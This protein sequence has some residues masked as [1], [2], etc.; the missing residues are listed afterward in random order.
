MHNG[1]S[2]CT[3]VQYLITCEVAAAAAGPS[4]NCKILSLKMF[5]IVASTE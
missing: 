4:G 1:W 2:Y 3:T 5:R